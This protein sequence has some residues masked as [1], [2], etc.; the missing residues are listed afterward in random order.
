MYNRESDKDVRKALSKE[1][2]WIR[3]RLLKIYN[4][5]NLQNIKMVVSLREQAFLKTYCL[6]EINDFI[7]FKNQLFRYL[8][9]RFESELSHHLTFD[10]SFVLF[11]K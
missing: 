6:T 8:N 5:I 11:K 4:N 7:E 9:D 1:K 3:S 10:Q 2:T